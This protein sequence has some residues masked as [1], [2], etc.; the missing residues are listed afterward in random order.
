MK[1]FLAVLLSALS[2]C[3]A[4]QEIPRSPN[5]PEDKPV[6]LTKNQVVAYEAAIAPYVAQARS[7][8]PG[9]KARF[10]AGLPAGYIFAVTTR[11][12]GDNG[13]FE[14]VFVTVREIKGGMIQGILA[15]H[16]NV[17]Q[18]YREGDSYAFPEA[19]L[20]DWVIVDRDGSEEGNVVGKFLDTY[21]ADGTAAVQNT[22]DMLKNAEATGAALFA[23]I[24]AKNFARPEDIKNFEALQRA[25]DRQKC[26]DTAISWAILPDRAR[27]TEIFGISSAASDDQVVIGRHFKASVVDGAADLSTL[28]AST[29]GCLILKIPPGGGGRPGAKLVGAYT[30]ELISTTPTEFHVLESK[31]HRIALFVSAGGEVWEVNNGSIRSADE[32]KE[33]LPGT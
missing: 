29:K 32:L 27:G 24:Q 17:V 5:A 19:E 3:A 11:L 22:A 15:S 6:P 2:I 21:H 30:T 33:H 9:A 20:L 12:H 31:L 28:A 25:I 8:Y 13:T 10:L 14:Q 18:G 7:T 23:A 4:A 1:R 16:I 26:K